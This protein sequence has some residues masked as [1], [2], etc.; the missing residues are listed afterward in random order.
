VATMAEA[1]KMVGGRLTTEASGGITRD[2]VGR[3]A[4]S[5]VDYISSGALTHSVTNLDIGLDIEI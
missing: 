3:I 2:T 5:G 4:E 1:V